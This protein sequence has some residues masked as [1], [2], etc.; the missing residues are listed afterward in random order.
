MDASLS[1][2]LFIFLDYIITLVIGYKLSRLEGSFH[3]IYLVCII[4]LFSLQLLSIIDIFIFIASLADFSI[5]I[6]T[7]LALAF[8]IYT[9]DFLFHNALWDQFHFT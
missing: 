4:V 6:F 5:F 7:K 9:S 2:R 8:N 3:A 1:S